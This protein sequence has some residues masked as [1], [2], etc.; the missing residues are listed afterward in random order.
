MKMSTQNMSVDGSQELWCVQE[1]KEPAPCVPATRN[2]FTDLER[3]EL[4]ESFR[5]VMSE[6]GL[7]GK[8]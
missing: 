8:D 3:E 2:V 4:K 1:S 6:Y 5:E 7:I